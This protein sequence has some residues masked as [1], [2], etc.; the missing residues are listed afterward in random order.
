MTEVVTM[1]TLADGDTQVVRS[2]KYDADDHLLVEK[3]STINS[4]AEIEEEHTVYYDANGNTLIDV[5]TQTV[6]NANEETDKL[7]TYFVLGANGEQVEIT[8]QQAEK[9]LMDSYGGDYGTYELSA[10]SDGVVD[11]VDESETEIA[12]SVE[13]DWGEYQLNADN[14]AVYDA[15]SEVLKWL[16]TIPETVRVSIKTTFESNPYL[17]PFL[18]YLSGEKGISLNPYPEVIEEDPFEAAAKYKPIV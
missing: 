15:V 1:N 5:V 16:E 12:T 8:A 18:D 11:A 7:T 9:I 2:Y 4:E 17:A 14:G 3:I 10:N 6:T 13:D